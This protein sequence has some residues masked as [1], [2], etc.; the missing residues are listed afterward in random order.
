MRFWQW[1]IP[2]LLLLSGVAS[3]APTVSSV[4]GT[5]S[6][7]QSI[8]ISG[9]SFGTK[10]TAGPALYDN[11]DN[12]SAGNTICNGSGSGVAP[13]IYQGVL[14]S[15]SQWVMD[16]GGEYSGQ[17]IVYNATDPIRT[18]S[19]HGR[20]SI[21]SSACWGTNFYV[22][23]SSWFTSTGSELYV[24]FLLRYTMSSYTPRQ[25]KAFIGYDSSWNDMWYMSTAFGSS[26]EGSTSWRL[27]VTQTSSEDYFDVGGNSIYGEWVRVESYIKQSG[28]DTS[29][30]IWKGY[31]HRP[32]LS[33]PT[34]EAH[35]NTGIK[36][37]TSSTNTSKLTLGAAYYSM[38]NGTQ[39]ATFDVDEIYID[40]TPARVEIGN[41]STWGACTRRVLQV[42]TS[43]SSSSITATVNQG[44]FANGATGY[45]YVVATDGSVN[46][47]GKEITF[48][49]SGGGGSSTAAT[50]QGCV[51]SGG[52]SM[53]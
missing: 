28:A 9:S 2:I 22:P 29:D 49:S 37:R 46:T 39:T 35:E 33:T 31:L 26:C 11:F 48:G 21:G 52:G 34:I 15:Y 16:G 19:L 4:S 7:G 51:V 6:H 10:T 32:T 43:W 47:T 36:L 12:G 38:C 1:I 41:A 24:S 27:H 17:S 44:G 18:G 25:F 14:S 3:A 20:T 13:Q 30:G 23:L 42:P 5:V 45:V 8:T 50:A 40:S 53:R